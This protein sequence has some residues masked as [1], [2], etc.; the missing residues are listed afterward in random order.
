V[1]THFLATLVG[2]IFLVNQ[3]NM[4][5]SYMSSKIDL[6]NIIMVTLELILGDQYKAFTEDVREL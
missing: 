4:S 6:K 3:P 1:S 5:C 2:K